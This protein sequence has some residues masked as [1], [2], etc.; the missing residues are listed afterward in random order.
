M[1]AANVVYGLLLGLVLF[2]LSFDLRRLG[3]YLIAVRRSR[4]VAQ[5][6]LR[7]GSLPTLMRVNW[8]DSEGSSSIDTTESAEAAMWSVSTR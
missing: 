6:P 1:S 4:R 8:N 2:G 3:R 7:P 5:I